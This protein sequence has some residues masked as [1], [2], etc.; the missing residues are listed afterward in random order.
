MS[1]KHVYYNTCTNLGYEYSR[2]DCSILEKKSSMLC[3]FQIS[4]Y[5]DYINILAI[6][7]TI[8]ITFLN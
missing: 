3:F 1:Y 6:S 5:I 2:V 4:K 8:I 7:L